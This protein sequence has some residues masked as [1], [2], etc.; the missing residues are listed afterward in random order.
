M[1][2]PI[3]LPPGV[4]YIL[5][6]ATPRGSPNF[7]KNVITGPNTAGQTLD[8]SPYNVN[9]ISPY[10]QWLITGDGGIMNMGNLNYFA[11][12]NE[13]GFTVQSAQVPTR[14]AISIT[15]A[16]TGTANDSIPGQSNLP[17][18]VGTIMTAD[19]QGKYWY[20]N[21]NDVMLTGTPTLWA[22]VN[23]ASMK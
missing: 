21:N 5:Q 12:P 14:S 17:G 7:N 22:F 15:Q 23:V 1:S 4:Y 2:L 3:P 10:Q 8:F 9:S 11:V 16:Y 18:W 19:G 13:P 6:N 20:S